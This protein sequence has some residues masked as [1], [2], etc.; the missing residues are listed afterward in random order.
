VVARGMAVAA[1]L[2]LVAGG[3]RAASLVIDTPG[4]DISID[5]SHA[6]PKGDLV[7]PSS[8]GAPAP[9]RPPSVFS[10]PLPSGSGARA[11]GLDGAFTA[12]ADDA[13]AAS[14]NPAGLL[15]L[16]RPEL[17][18]VYRYGTESD[19]H[20]SGDSDF[21]VGEN[22]FS[23]ENLNYFSLVYPF[24]CRPLE[25][26]MVVSLNYQEAYDFGQEFTADVSGRTSGSDSGSS[27]D[28]F[29]G[30]QVDTI[31][32]E[33]FDVTITSYKTTKVSSSFEQL[34]AS[35]LLSDVN[36]DQDGVIAAWSPAMAVEVTPKLSAGMAVNFYQIDPFSGGSIRSRTTAA[37]SGRSESRVDSRTTRTTSGTFDYE[38]TVSLPPGGGIP[39]PIEFDIADSGEFDP[40]TDTSHASRRDAVEVDGTYE[41]VNEFE[42]LQGQNAT[43]GLLYTLNRYL[44]FGAS[45]DLP[46]TADARQTKTVQSRL[47]T[48]NDARTRVLNVTDT[49]STEVKDVEF[50]FPLYW[51]VGTVVRW[52]PQLYTTLDV[53]ETLWSDFAYQAADEEKINPL[54]GQPHAESPLDDT[55]AARVGT[56]YLVML[57]RME[58]PLRCGAGWEQRPAVGAPDDYYS[59]ALGSGIAFGDDPGR[60]LIDFAYVYTFASDVR[61]IVPDQTTLTSDVHEHQGYVSVIK[62]F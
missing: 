2:L 29:H 40:F 39:I 34:L 57:R 12:L 18:A 46:W 4:G 17:S 11:L 49:S 54:N 35:D 56:E 6:G 32:D 53:S 45:V 36:F 47:T 62:H 20:V 24:L 3:T 59:L 22:E 7:T 55:W 10:A 23:G 33:V 38:G 9:F 1:T 37:Y 27:S 41:E 52:T 42:D 50:D 60:V 19:R 31:K 14:W 61:G 28:T 43:F 26:N 13:T 8:V 44:S 16:E 58:I 51:A 48:L 15:Q 5:I 21:R 25:R 30:T